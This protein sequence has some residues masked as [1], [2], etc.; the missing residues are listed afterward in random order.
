MAQLIVRRLDPEIVRQL[1]IRAARH[2]RS[3]EEEHREILRRALQP[4]PAGSLKELLLEMPPA[5][6]DE[7]FERRD[8][9]GRTS[10]L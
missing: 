7:D 4:A 8:D 3:A 9:V 2:G 6:D 5:G 1:R 10:T